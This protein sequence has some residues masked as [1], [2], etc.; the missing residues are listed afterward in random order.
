[1][2]YNYKNTEA[3][4]VVNRDMQQSASSWSHHQIPLATTAL[5]FFW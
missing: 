4:A 5:M 1:M 2:H 3:H